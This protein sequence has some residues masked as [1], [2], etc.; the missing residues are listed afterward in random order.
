MLN[1]T[2]HSEAL[3]KR[4]REVSTAMFEFGQSITWL[5]QSEGDVIGTALTQMGTSADTLS[6]SAS[7]HAEQEAIKLL[8]PL[9]EYSRMLTSIKTAMQQRQDKKT[10]YLNAMSDLDGKQNAHRKLIGVAGKESQA[11][12]KEQAAQVAQEA[13]DNAKLDFEKVSERLLNEFELFKNQKA[14][15]M[16]EIIL[17]FVALQIE[18]NQKSEEAWSELLPKIQAVS[19]A[20]M[21]NS[22]GGYSS[23]ALNSSSNPFGGGGDN[24]GYED[25]ASASQQQEQYRSNFREQEEDDD[26]MVGV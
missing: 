21:D 20:E 4:S 13:T 1:V 25:F 9:E 22:S 19:I 3:V 12:A 11:S 17:S 10:A 26:G 14:L 16:K 15:D 24:G 18:F 23:G 2:K 5:G 6:V 8:E 7:A